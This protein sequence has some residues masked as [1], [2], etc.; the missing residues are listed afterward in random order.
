MKTTSYEIPCKHGIDDLYGLYAFVGADQ[1]IGSSNSIEEY[2]SSEGWLLYAFHCPMTDEAIAAEIQR[3][4]EWNEH[5]VRE[6]RAQGRYGESYIV[7]M[8][9][10]DNPLLYN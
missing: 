9:L 3:R 7:T 8:T 1:G 2:L 6:L 4:K 10:V 5:Y